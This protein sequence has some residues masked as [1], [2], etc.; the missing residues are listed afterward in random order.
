MIQTGAVEIINEA[1]VVLVVLS[2]GS[3]FGEVALL[4]DFNRTAGARSSLY[5]TCD[6]LSKADFD[7]IRERYPD[8]NNQLTKDIEKDYVFNEN[9]DF[10]HKGVPKPGLSHSFGDIA[11]E[12]VGKIHERKIREK[13]SDEELNSLTNKSSSLLGVVVKGD[14][15]L[16]EVVNPIMPKQKQRVTVHVPKS[17]LQPRTSET[18]RLFKRSSTG[19]HVVVNKGG[20]NVTGAARRATSAVPAGLSVADEAAVRRVV[21]TAVKEEMEGLKSWLQQAL[22]QQH[23]E[24]EQLNRDRMRKISTSSAGR[25][26]FGTVTGPSRKAA[27]GRSSSSLSNRS[28]SVSDEGK[29]VDV[30]REEEKMAT[31]HES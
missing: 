25:S 15:S 20:S 26:K 19:S 24:R 28:M 3:Y 5:T 7:L 30:A 23:T 12:V 8:F 1:G 13:R 21:Q 29:Q 4:T 2:E 11:G 6:T 10:G 17:T 14:S 9:T 22:K 16:E 27:G 31:T 18:T